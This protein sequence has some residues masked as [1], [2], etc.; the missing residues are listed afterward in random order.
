MRVV[1]VVNASGLQE[2]RAAGL[3]RHSR[4]HVIRTLVAPSAA[5]VAKV[6]RAAE[7]AYV[8]DPG[9]SGAVGAV[10]ARLAR[11]P[12]V[13]ELGDP[14][15]LL[16]RGQGRSAASVAV[17]QAIDHAVARRADAV[18]VRGRGLVADLAIRRPWAFLPDGVD[19][20]LFD[21]A[22]VGDVRAGLGI[23][24][25]TLV[26]G[27]VGSLTWSGTHSW[28]YG[29]ELV[30]ALAL[31]SDLPVVGLIVGDGTG[32]EQLR[33]RAAKHGVASRV[34]TTGRVPHSE[35]PP[36]LKAM[37]I[38][39][40]TQTNDP[41]GRG[42]TTAKLPEYLACDR[43]VLASRVGEAA[44][45]LPEE[46]LL[47]YKDAFDVTYPRLLADRVRALFP[48]QQ[49][50]RVSGG[51]RALAQAHFGYEQLADQW[52]DILEQTVQRRPHKLRLRS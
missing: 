32:L 3:A 37:D 15:G 44:A 52:D 33:W 47:P 49:Q 19:L 14:Q 48:R 5:R 28:C 9:R 8:I 24:D 6:A 31:L 27:L 25:G 26:V 12:C 50:L 21:D 13:I 17:G 34:I 18:V 4:H 10:A 46:M 38:C 40:S 39:V 1:V 36:L 29:M 42:R 16:Y 20:E 22:N 30:E 43:F 11:T 45:V 51:T 23:A 41:I 2:R 7:V 35:V